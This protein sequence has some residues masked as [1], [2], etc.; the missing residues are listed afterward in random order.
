MGVEGGGG[1]FGLITNFE[2]ELHPFG[3]EAMFC[4]PIYPIE[5]AGRAIRV[6]RDF[7]AD[8]NGIVGSLAEF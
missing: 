8:K 1:N 7:L 3:P 6:R 5:H 2:F 4:A